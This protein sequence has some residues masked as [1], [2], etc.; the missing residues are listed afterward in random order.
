MKKTGLMLLAAAL[1]LGQSPYAQ[2]C[3]GI[4]RVSIGKKAADRLITLWM[5]L[6]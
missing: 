5:K 6:K 4:S 2:A 3:T 1:L